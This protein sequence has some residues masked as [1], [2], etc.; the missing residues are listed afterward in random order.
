MCEEL[1]LFDGFARVD[2]VVVVVGWEEELEV[3]EM[4]G[5]GGRGETYITRL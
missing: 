1:K 4:V 5:F 2:K 3:E